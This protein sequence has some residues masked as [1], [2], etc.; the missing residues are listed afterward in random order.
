MVVVEFSA[1]SGLLF[2]FLCLL[3]CS[4][5]T[6]WVS[7]ENSPEGAAAYWDGWMGWGIEHFLRLTLSFCDKLFF[8][9]FFFLQV[10]HLLV[11]QVIGN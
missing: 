11:A 10:L 4:F 2:F 5:F 7:F 3:A 1:F 9:L 6:D 8:L